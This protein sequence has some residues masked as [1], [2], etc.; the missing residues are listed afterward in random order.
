MFEF[1]IA[2]GPRIYPLLHTLILRNNTEQIGYQ[3]RPIW[4]SA[5]ESPVQ[6]R[7]DAKQDQT[8]AIE[9]A[10]NTTWPHPEQPRL[11]R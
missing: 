6:A 3:A 10:E 1:Y 11:N 7:T 5:T 9:L 4:P 2:M 8:Q